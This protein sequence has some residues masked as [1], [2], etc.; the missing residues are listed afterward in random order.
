MALNMEQV[1]RAND[2]NRAVLRKLEAAVEG[3]RVRGAPPGAIHELEAH[4]EKYRASLRRSE[5]LETDLATMK[6]RANERQEQGF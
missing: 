4:L 1:R 6:G 2:I 5:E 3:A